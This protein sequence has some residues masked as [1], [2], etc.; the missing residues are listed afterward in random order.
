MVQLVE[1]LVDQRVKPLEEAS[2]RRNGLNW[3]IGSARILG[4]GG[5]F[6]WTAAR[7]SQSRK[8][9]QKERRRQCS[10]GQ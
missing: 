7:Q 5:E 3:R 10:N 6:D 2:S 4:R 1:C 9:G 8:G